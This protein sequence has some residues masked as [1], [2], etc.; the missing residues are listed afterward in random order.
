M[1]YKIYYNNWYFKM[2]WMKNYS[3]TVLGRIILFKES[4]E[5]VSKKLLDHELIHQKQMDVHGVLGFYI[6]YLYEYIKN[7]VKYRNHNQA[8]LNI[9]FEKE[10]Y[11]NN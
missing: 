3:G 2:P 6:K 1:N 10:A 7:L 8:Y 9:P 5:V 11:K 4:K